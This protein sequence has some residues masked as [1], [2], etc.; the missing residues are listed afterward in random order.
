MRNNSIFFIAGC[1]F[2]AILLPATTAQAGQAKFD[3]YVE[4]QQLMHLIPAGNDSKERCRP[5]NG[6][7]QGLAGYRADY[8][9]NSNG[10]REFL[11]GYRLGEQFRSVS[12]NRERA[13]R[14]LRNE[15]DKR[16]LLVRDYKSSSRTAQQKT[17]IVN[18]INNFDQIIRRKDQKVRSMARE[19]NGLK[20]EISSFRSRNR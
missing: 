19:I 6:L 3:R 18:Q 4:R 1:A 8:Y 20:R 5:V 13:V 12:E 10:L 15:L 2:A 9:C 16:N 17:R 11:R 14:D 7:E